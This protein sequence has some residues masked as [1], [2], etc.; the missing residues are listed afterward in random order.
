[1]WVLVALLVVVWVLG[2]VAV[3][4]VV[5]TLVRWMKSLAEFQGVKVHRSVC[6]LALAALLFQKGCPW[7][8][9][10]TL[11][12]CLQLFFSLLKPFLCTRKTAFGKGLCFCKAA[13]KVLPLEKG[14][15]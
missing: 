1:M 12:L 9:A 5:A 13:Q 3:S 15:K 11:L 2:L 8:P 14:R 10:M 4:G 7:Y 6:K